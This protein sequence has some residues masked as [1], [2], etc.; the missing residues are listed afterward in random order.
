[1]NCKKRKTQKRDQLLHV[2]YGATTGARCNCTVGVSGLKFV[3]NIHNI[4]I[5]IAIYYTVNY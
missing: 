3:L 2:K 1:M 5:F 4:Y